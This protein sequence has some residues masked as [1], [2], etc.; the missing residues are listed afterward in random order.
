M[1]SNRVIFQSYNPYSSICSSTRVVS[2]E[3]LHLIKMFRSQGVEVSVEP[4][5]GTKLN[6]VTKK[7]WKEIIS[8]PIFLFVTG[9]PLNFALNLISSWL[10][11]NLKLKKP[12]PVE[13]FPI[14]IEYEENDKK[15]KYTHT[16]QPISDDKLLQILIGMEQR[17]KQCGVQSKT[18]PIKRS[19]PFPI[20][21]EHTNKIVGQADK[22]FKDEI[23][24]QIEG[25]KITDEET[26]LRIQSGDLQGWSV[27]GVI[28][29]SECSICKDEYVNCNHMSPNTYK[30][31]QVAIKIKKM[32]IAEI[33]IVKEPIQPLAKINI[34]K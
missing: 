16:G 1:E 32:C 29:S 6:Y 26:W 28:A 21:L 30:G 7:G 14:V 25:I 27:G 34:T 23:G 20:Y 9:I 8:D 33:S 15:L 17:K 24:M 11:D 18:S 22:I 13:N 4:E 2:R 31:K 12:S 19:D 3:T 10:Y 5:D